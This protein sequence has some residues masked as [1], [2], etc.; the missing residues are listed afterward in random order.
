MA[1]NKE[2]TQQIETLLIIQIIQNLQALIEGVKQ[3][4][5]T[6]SIL[7]KDVTELKI[8]LDEQ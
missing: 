5:K 4:S 1:K 3:L 8:R 2:N 6:I 7:N